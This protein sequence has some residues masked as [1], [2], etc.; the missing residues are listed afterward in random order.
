MVSIFSPP[1]TSPSN[2]E[3]SD[4][5]ANLS[6]E[7]LVNEANA[8]FAFRGIIDFYLPKDFYASKLEG[9]I[10]EMETFNYLL[11]KTLPDFMV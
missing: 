3:N 5:V 8:L 4:T 9:L 11:G 2:P 6:E 1:G 7:N 10:A